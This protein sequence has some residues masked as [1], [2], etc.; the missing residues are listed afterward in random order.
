MANDFLGDMSQQ[1]HERTSIAFL[2]EF[3]DVY[4]QRISDKEVASSDECGDI[5]DLVEQLLYA[6]FDDRRNSV[7]IRPPTPDMTYQELIEYINDEVLHFISEEKP[8]AFIYDAKDGK[9]YSKD[10]ED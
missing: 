7:P 6:Y 4:E 10:L 5:C 1:D 8:E 9:Y 3:R 2:L